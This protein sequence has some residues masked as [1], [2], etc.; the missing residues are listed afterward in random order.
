MPPRP[1][2]ARRRWRSRPASAPIF[3]SRKAPRTSRWRSISSRM[4]SKWPISTAPA[5]QSPASLPDNFTLPA[6]PIATA[7]AA[8]GRAAGCRIRHRR[9]REGRHAGAIYQ[10]ERARSPALLEKGMAW[11]F[12]GTAGL[13]AEPW[14]TFKRGETVVLLDG[15]QPHQIRPAAPYPRPCL[16]ALDD[17]GAR[18]FGAT[19][20]SSPVSRRRAASL[21]RRQSGRL[22]HHSH[23]RRARRISGLITSLPGRVR[24]EI[25]LDLANWLIYPLAKHLTEEFGGGVS[26]ELLFREVDEEVRQEQIKKTL[27]PIRQLIIIALCVVVVLAVAAFKGWQYW[28]LTQSEAAR[29]LCKRR[30]SCSTMAKTPRLMRPSPGIGHPGYGTLAR[31]RLAAALAGARQDRRSGRCLRCRRRRCQSAD[32]ALRDLARYARR[33]SAGRQAGPGGTHQP[34]WLLRQ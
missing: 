1:V 3:W 7:F 19:P 14:Q 5:M 10:G 34:A 32:Q 26:D 24:L 15:R 29:S 8:E 27:G 28:Q 17:R 31:L 2:G 16:A 22:G 25:C 23:H 33:L 11:A 9:R 18:P 13:A 12:N 30:S 6:N 21:R 20:W 4:S